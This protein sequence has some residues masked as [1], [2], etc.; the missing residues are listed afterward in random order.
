M[1]KTFSMSQW[2]TVMKEHGIGQGERLQ[3][4]IEQDL[5]KWERLQKLHALIGLPIDV[6]TDFNPA[7]ILADV[8]TVKE[9]FAGHKNARFS[10]KAEPL[11][12]F[13]EQ[14]PRHRKHGISQQECVA[15]V[16]DLQPKPQ[17]YKISIWEYFES[18]VSGTIVIGEKE[19]LV[20]AVAGSHS[21]LT[22]G[23][24]GQIVR[25]R[26][27][28]TSEELEVPDD[29]LRPIVKKALDALRCKG[30]SVLTFHGF[31]AGYFEFLYN[32]MLGLRFIDYNTTPMMSMVD[33]NKV[34]GIVGGFMASSGSCTGRACVVLDEKDFPKVQL[35]DVL[36][37]T[38][39]DP[40]FVPLLAKAVGI[41]T[42]FGGVTCHA[43]IIARELGIPC[44][45]GTGNGTTLLKDGDE[46]EITEGKV[47]LLRND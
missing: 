12:Q 41:I 27:D 10:I 30:S 44:I 13:T 7:D 14:L 46:I 17:D 47:R 9:F 4:T 1:Q 37:T 40:Q 36:V 45:V 39:T 22:Q 42:D 34:D 8:K 15:F 25:T 24:K 28:Y 29:E 33:V 21:I 6:H 32:K 20:E 19:A 18:D 11:E 35:G 43:A 5:T 38:M 23:W 3:K 26:Y 2:M 31:V 16:R